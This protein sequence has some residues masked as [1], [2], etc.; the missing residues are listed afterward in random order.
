METH[1]PIRIFAVEDDPI[2]T[3][4]LTYVFDLNPDIEVDFFNDGKSC[5]AELHRL[6]N[7]ITLDYS[8]PDMSGDEVL[9]AIRQADPN[10]HVIIVSGQEDISTAIDLLKHGAYD[11]IAK[12]DDTKDRLLM[13]IKNATNNVNLIQ[14]VKALKKEIGEKYDFSNS[15]LGS[16]PAI[17]K[18]FNLME[19]AIQTNI[20]VSITGETGTGKEL[21]AKAI[22]YHSNRKDENFVAVNIAAIP[23]ELLESELFGHEKGA[24]TGAN[25]RRIG[26][27]EEATNGTIFLD[28]IGEMDIN[29]QAK[30]L[31]VLQ[32][33]EITRIGGNDVIKI[34]PRIVAATHRDLANEVS[35]GNF[36]EDLYYR[37]LGLPI[38]IPP[39]RDRG[40]DII[41]IALKMLKDFCHENKLEAISLSTEA[42]E[43]LL[44][45][46]YPGNVRELKSIIELAAVM[47]SNSVITDTD[48]VF[49]SVKSED[50]FT[51]E[52][53]TMKEYETRIID[54]Y[55][56][57]YDNNVLKIAQKLDIGKS[58]IYRHLKSRKDAGEIS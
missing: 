36:R 37:L 40:N 26:K 44:S 9:S 24:F 52:N 56:Q 55:M 10:I 20:T 41:L 32:E 48:I 49:K 3:K 34:N 28:E 27:F 7:I 6:P 16:S 43:K 25:T 29:M 23:N 19:K 15:I 12:N 8:L 39:L 50:N 33:K 35:E 31:R 4:F 47:C 14:E 21:V 38:E 57:K 11:Y 30:I 45:Y 46:S 51:F 13:T 53:L 18:V 5:L 2:Y 22:H 1:T 58:T 42:K 17:K 54:Y